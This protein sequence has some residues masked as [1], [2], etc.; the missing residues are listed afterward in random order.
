MAE[1]LQTTVDKFTFRV[2]TDRHY[3]MDGIW[4]Q[5]LG[6]G[7]VRVGVTDF[8]QQHSG[9]VAF[10]TVRPAG[11]LIA[12]GGEF[13]DLETVKVNVAMPLP[14]AGTIVEVNV[15]LGTTPE[16]VNQ[17]P[18][19]DGWLAV[20]QTPSWQTDRLGLLDPTAYLAVMQ[21]QAEQELNRP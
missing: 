1:Y 20:V 2:A 19:G 8:V 9:D 13:A 21:S 5:D 14:I 12:A 3:S 10:A 16:V 17:S 7:R 4:L 6:D 15:A 18:Y 11:T